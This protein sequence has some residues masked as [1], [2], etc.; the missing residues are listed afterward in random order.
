MQHLVA[1]PVEIL[2]VLQPLEVGDDHAAR[3]AEHVGD[4]LDVVALRE[5]LVGGERGGA[6]GSLGEHAAAQ[7]CGG[8]GVDDAFERGRHEHGALEGEQLFVGDGL[9]AVE[10]AQDPLRLQVG[11]SLFHVDAAR[12]VN[13]RGVIGDR[14][15]LRAVVRERESGLAADVAETLKR[16]GGALDGNLQVLE[17]SFYQIRDARAGG[18]AA[19]LRAAERNGFAG[20]A[21]WFVATEEIGIRVHHP[22]HDLFVGA[23]VGRGHVDVRTD[24][25]RDFLDVA[26]GKPFEFALG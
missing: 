18:L 9:A 14:D 13:A 15:D 21:G 4:D 19:S 26:A 12:V 23:H 3:V 7:L 10:V 8:L 2:Q 24:D 20:D 6:V 11:E 17:V 25:R 5:D 16:D 1:L 22:A